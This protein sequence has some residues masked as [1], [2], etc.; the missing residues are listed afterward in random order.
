MLNDLGEVDKG[1]GRHLEDVQRLAGSAGNVR[2]AEHAVEQVGA[3]A[4][5]TRDPQTMDQWSD[6]D[7]ASYS[8]WQ[9][10][11]GFSGSDAS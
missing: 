11:L 1:I 2:A 8:K 6:A 7:K 5:R 4:Q 10:K 3:V 9:R